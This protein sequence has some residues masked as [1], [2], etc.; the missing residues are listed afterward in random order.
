MKKVQYQTARVHWHNG[1]ALLPEHFYAQ[2]E[3]LRAEVALLLRL[4][5]APS[6][7]L[8]TLSLGV[9]LTKG[10]VSI[11]EMSLVLP[12]GTILDI[13]G[14]T[15]PVTLNLNDAGADVVPVYV[16]LEGGPE[17]VKP[18]AGDPREEGI[19]RMLRKVKLS[20]NA[21]CETAV[22]P[23]FKLAVFE[24]DPLKVWSLRPD[25]LPPFI[26]VGRAAPLFDDQRLRMRAITRTLRQM[27][28][29]EVEQNHLNSDTQAAT[30]DALRGVF[31]FAGLLDDLDQGIAPHPYD[32]FRA[33]RAFYVEVC[34]LRGLDP[35]ELGSRYEHENLGECLALLIEALEAQTQGVHQDAPYIPFTRREGMLECALG[36][37]VTRARDVYLLIKKPQVSTKLELRGVKL[38]SPMRLDTV[39]AR[40]LEGIK[41]KLIDNPPFGLSSN[42][43]F[44]GITQGVE[45]DHALRESKIVLLDAPTLSK[46]KLYLY[47]RPE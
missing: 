11:H 44:Y 4:A 32:L 6:W 30:K 31:S 3:S 42:V 39:N 23:P 19:E 34:V 36:P 26:C 33:L 35:A 25:Y 37:E 18:E 13:P 28:R 16:H 24:R 2:E 38:A 9:E 22:Q 14:N 45:W 29:E 21:A 17:I 27:L 7:G 40:A 15:G 12:S 46:S 10:I 1:Q 47:S 8:G 20:C 43:E 5:P 41:L